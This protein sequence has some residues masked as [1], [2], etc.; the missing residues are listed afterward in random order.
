MSPF[1]RSQRAVEKQAAGRRRHAKPVPEKLR[2][3]ELPVGR[4]PFVQLLGS[5]QAFGAGVPVELQPQEYEFPHVELP[6]S[7]PVVTAGML[8]EVLDLDDEANQELLSAM[9]ELEADEEPTQ[10]IAVTGTLLDDEPQPAR[11]VGL[12]P[13]VAPSIPVPMNPFLN[14][15]PPK[16]AR[17]AVPSGSAL[18]ARLTDVELSLLGRPVP[19]DAPPMPSLAPAPQL[20]QPIQRDREHPLVFSCFDEAFWRERHEEIALLNGESIR[21]AQQAART[22]VA[23]DA[24]LGRTEAA[25]QLLVSRVAAVEYRGQLAE[26][27]RALPCPLP[28]RVP[29][30]ALAA[31]EAQHGELVSA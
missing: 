11:H 12:V 8:R 27:V 25:H 21:L 30:A 9:A 15:H 13:A 31:I 19:A 3:G 7:R 6:V 23:M 22:A 20:Y 10:P 24:Q 14:A 26:S 5:P 2:G 1:K 18:P 4:V 16:H 17:S 29:G 28:K